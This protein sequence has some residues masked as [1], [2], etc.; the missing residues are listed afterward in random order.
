MCSAGH[1]P[2]KTKKNMREVCRYLT[3]N[4]IERTQFW[5]KVGSVLVCDVEA[6]E[7]AM[8]RKTTGQWQQRQQGVAVGYCRCGAAYP[9]RDKRGGDR[10]ARRRRQRANRERSRN[11][12]VLS[13]ILADTLSP[14]QGGSGSRIAERPSKL[15]VLQQFAVAGSGEGRNIW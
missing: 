7:Q 13:R 10:T 3:Q 9:S 4:R 15:Q 14:L 12:R 5:R 8:E 6:L 1:G 2:H 11:D